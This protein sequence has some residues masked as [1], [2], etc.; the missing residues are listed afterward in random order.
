[1]YELFQTQNRRIR[2]G[3]WWE[4]NESYLFMYMIFREKINSVLKHLFLVISGKLRLSTANQ[5]FAGWLELLRRK[6]SLNSGLRWTK[7]AGEIYLYTSSHDSRR[8]IAAFLYLVSSRFVQLL[9][10]YHPIQKVR[11]LS[12]KV[13]NRMMEYYDQLFAARIYRASKSISTKR[14]LVIMWGS[15]FNESV[16]WS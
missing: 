9:M 16:G 13:G 1:M 8:L 6:S 4:L 5:I 2:R 12:W 11:S 3:V 7:S 15:R 14:N 10:C